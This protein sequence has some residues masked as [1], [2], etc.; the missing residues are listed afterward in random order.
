MRE[1]PEAKAKKSWYEKGF[2]KKGSS[3]RR[4]ISKGGKFFKKFQN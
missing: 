4:K 3:S 2:R 1:A